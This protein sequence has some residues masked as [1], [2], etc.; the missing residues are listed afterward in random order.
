MT[1]K[2]G[3]MS[4]ELRADAKLMLPDQMLSSGIDLS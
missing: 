1:N 3:E 4:L 2:M